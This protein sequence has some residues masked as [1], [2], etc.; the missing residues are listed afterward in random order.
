MKELFLLG[1]GATVEAGVPASTQM[2][3]DMLSAFSEDFRLR[4]EYRVLKFVVGG[5]LFQAGA[6][7]SNP[8]EGIN[9]EDLFNTVNLLGEKNDSE[10]SPFVGS[11]HPLLQDFQMGD[12][13][14]STASAMLSNIYEPIKD[15]VDDTS[16]SRG[17]SRIN[18]FHIR[19]DFQR[20]FT[21]AVRQSL[22]SKSKWIFH[23][24]GEAMIEKLIDMVWLTDPLSVQYL[25]PLVKHASVNKSAIVTLNYDNSIELAGKGINLEIDTGFESWSRS[26]EFKYKRNLIP[27]IK[28][29][30]S[31]D[32][33]LDYEPRSNTKIFPSQSISK[34]NPENSKSKKYR[35][36]IVFGGKNKLTA[37]GPSLSL[38][39]AFERELNKCTLLITV[40]YSFHDDHVNEFIKNWLN[41]N[42]AREMKIIDPS[43][44]SLHGEFIDLL[45]KV[46][47]TNRV[48]IIKETTGRAFKQFFY[49]W[50]DL[51]DN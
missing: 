24:T 11:W 22:G 15:Y 12:I 20:N 33:A 31:I 18:D 25:H 23:Q 47:P 8:F 40:G 30:G 34:V 13:S 38:L 46:I 36:A 43:F 32:W 17:H 19:S 35:P 1:A 51:D 41:G 49:N 6:K 16:S 29:H 48:Q 42:Q 50:M 5:L 9:I 2:T 10:L 45:R 3:K 7:G 37:N 39:R 28:L 44:E 27:L 4:H 14:S 26:G 21:E